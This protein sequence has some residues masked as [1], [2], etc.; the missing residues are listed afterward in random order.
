MSMYSL[1]ESSDSYSKT[2]GSSWQYYRDE[3]ALTKAGAI[4]NIHPANNSALFKI[5]QKITRETDPANGRKNV[6]IMV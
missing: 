2:S 5:K 6:E 4:A 1:I 3:S